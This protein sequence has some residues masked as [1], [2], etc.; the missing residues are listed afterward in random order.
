[1]K[2]MPIGH[3]IPHD[4]HDPRAKGAADCDELVAVSIK[5]AV[6]RADGPQQAD[7]HRAKQFSFEEKINMI[8]VMPRTGTR[9]RLPRIRGRTLSVIIPTPLY[10][11][12]S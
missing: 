11:P 8:G 4:K 6:Q 5:A 3:R 2:R 12:T 10:N 1:M 9:R 7:L